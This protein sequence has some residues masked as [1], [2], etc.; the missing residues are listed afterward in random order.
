MINGE[1]LFPAQGCFDT[2]VDDA[3]QFITF[4]GDFLQSGCC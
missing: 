2:G 4:V 1:L 3:A